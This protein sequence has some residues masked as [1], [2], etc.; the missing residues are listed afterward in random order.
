MRPLVVLSPHLD[1]AIL[2]CGGRIAR[3]VDA[4]RR[5]LVATLFTRDQPPAPPSA[6]AAELRRRWNL[7][8]GEVMA[9]RRAEDLEACRR[10]GAEPLHLDL[11]E[12]LYRSD[13][14]G[15]P[16]Y[17]TLG[18][19]FG[20]LAPA[21]LAGQRE[22]AGRIARLAEEIGGEPELFGP[23]GVGNHVDHQLARRALLQVR[24]H[25]ALY[26]EFPYTEWKWFA[27]S[28]AL[29]RAAEWEP[30]VLPVDAALLERRRHAIAAYASQVPAMFRTEGRLG[31]QLRRAARRAGGERVW[32]R[33][34][35]G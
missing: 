12:A 9:R 10:L 24:P 26:E 23:L 32:R 21:D 34:A 14:R 16:L 11:P 17:P 19:L 29:G 15:E 3:A 25:A 18:A 1:D 31:K 20:E 33:R 27:V 30:E 5:A 2:S 8:A 6:L 35:A 7:P 28:R 13:E 22:I 4:G